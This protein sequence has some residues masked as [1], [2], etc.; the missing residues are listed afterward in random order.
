MVTMI[1]KSI[2]QQIN[3]ILIDKPDVINVSDILSTFNVEMQRIFSNENDT[4]FDFAGF[5]GAVLCVDKNNK[6]IDYSGAK[7]PL[8]I[9]NNERKLNT[10]KADKYSVGY[11]NL[12]V[13]YKFTKK[14][15]SY[16]DFDTFYLCTDGYIDQT[17]G[18]NGFSFGR[19]AFEEIIIKHNNE[20][21][22]K[23]KE[24][25]MHSFNAYKRDE[26][27]IDDVTLLGFTL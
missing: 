16:E 19:K 23:Q 10:I 24:I 2:T 20:P 8:Y 27:Q 14:K 15:I 9:V 7:M 21:L 11:Q 6:S 22:S 4:A 18:K 13:N 25:L 5:D 12:D 3:S 1:V 17:G 26:E